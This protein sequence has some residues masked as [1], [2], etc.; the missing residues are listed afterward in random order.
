MSQILSAHEY[1]LYRLVPVA[2]M[3]EIERAARVHLCGE[4]VGRHLDIKRKIVDEIGELPI[5]AFQDITSG[6]IQHETLEN[7]LSRAHRRRWRPEPVR[8][9]PNPEPTCGNTRVGS[10]LNRKEQP[11]LH[12]PRRL[13]LADD[14]G[15]QEGENCRN[16]GYSKGWGSRSKIS[17]DCAS[18]SPGGGLCVHTLESLRFDSFRHYWASI[19]LSSGVQW[20]QWVVVG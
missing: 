10:L 14:H 2:I 12:I 7:H 8:G 17:V 18:L 11:Q 5:S 6:I 9:K 4:L 1:G 19:L 15:D 20:L 13:R 16:R 3:V